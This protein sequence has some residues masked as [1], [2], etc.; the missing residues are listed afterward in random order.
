MASVSQAVKGQ[1][2]I[3]DGIVGPDP[4]YCLRLIDASVNNN[5]YRYV[6]SEYSSD[7][8]EEKTRALPLFV[9]KR[10]VYDYIRKLASEKKITYVALATGA[11]LDWN[12]RHSFMNIDI[13]N[14]KVDLMNDGTNVF[15]WTLLPL[16]GR[17]FANALLRADETE[18]RTCYIHSIEKSQKQVLDLAKEALGPG[19]WQE[20]K[21]DMEK[22]LESALARWDTGNIDMELIGDFIRYANATPGYSGAFSKNDNELLGVEELSDGK[23]KQLIKDIATELK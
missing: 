17:A 12:L 2:A 22:V 20:K 4:Q 23:V 15:L 1:D 5:V 21:V 16:A 7:P 3:V 9:G 8:L 10:T 18:N 19:G 14:K 6:L 11:F 13:A